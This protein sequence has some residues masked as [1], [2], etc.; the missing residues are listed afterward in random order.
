MGINLN[1]SKINLQNRKRNIRANVNR[2]RDL[3]LDV[4]I[5]KIG[6]KKQRKIK[7]YYFRVNFLTQKAQKDDTPSR[8]E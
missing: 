7:K 1:P 3:N 5:A 6:L 4:I 2:D 8:S